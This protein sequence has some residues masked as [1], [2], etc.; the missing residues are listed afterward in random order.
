[1]SAQQAITF[2]RRQAPER[3]AL[4]PPVAEFGPSL[5]RV[6]GA[7]ALSGA[8]LLLVP[9]LLA[10]GHFVAALLLL[11]FCCPLL[12]LL[13]LRPLRQRV[14]LYPAGF[15]I[16]NG[17]RA[18]PFPFDAVARVYHHTEQAVVDGV[19]LP[20]RHSFT[21]VAEDGRRA[22]LSPFLSDVAALGEAIKQSV[23]DRLL[24]QA[25]DELGAGGEVDFDV[26]VV[27]PD[28]LHQGNGALRWEDLGEVAVR[29]GSLYVGDRRSPGAWGF[30]AVT[31]VPNL[32]VLL[33][34]ID[35]RRPR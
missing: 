21:V 34:L 12:W 24:R 31:K 2:E 10:A 32:E 11:A 14:R 22:H 29:G 16:L 18:E 26:V 27:R 13:C 28:G 4:G 20:T 9:F 23:F 33:A 7:G 35:R 1:M 15:T 25:L 6:L 30:W 5:P 3:A 8:P 19:P 17:S